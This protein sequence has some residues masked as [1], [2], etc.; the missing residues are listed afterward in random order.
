MKK[1]HFYF[2]QHVLSGIFFFLPDFIF[3]RMS[4]MF[5]IQKYLYY[6]LFFITPFIMYSG[7]SEL[8]EFNKMIYIYLITSSILCIWILR[9]ASQGRILFKRTPFDIPIVLFFLSQLLSTLFSIDM[10]TS[11]FG[12]YGRFNGG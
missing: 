5:K 12:Y 7:T 2:Q 4:Y 6:L 8:F 11:I 3:G 10:H 9:M 1:K